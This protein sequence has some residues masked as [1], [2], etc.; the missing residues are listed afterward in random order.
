[1]KFSSSFA[2]NATNPDHDLKLSGIEDGSV[3]PAGDEI[4]VKFWSAPT[5]GS[6]VMMT[7]GLMIKDQKDFYGGVGYNFQTN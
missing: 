1:M 2:M 6:N 3:L 7:Y 5:Q 4:V